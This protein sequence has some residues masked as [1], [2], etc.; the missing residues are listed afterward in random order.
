MTYNRGA[1]PDR[2][3]CI[4]LLRE[5]VERG[6]TLFDTAI[7]YGPLDNEELAGEALAPFRIA[8]A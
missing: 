8:S 1:H 2:K 6:V 3:Q 4:R 7:I 5:A